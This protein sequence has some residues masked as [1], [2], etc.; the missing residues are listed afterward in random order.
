MTSTLKFATWNILFKTRGIESS[1]AKVSFLK[2]LDW[3]V[4]ALQEVTE[5]QWADFREMELGQ[6][7]FHAFDFLPSQGRSSMAHGATL[8]A[9]NGF[10]LDDCVLFDGLPK[11]ERGVGAVISSNALRLNVASWH[12]PNASGD[13]VKTKMR[14]YQSF[15]DWL[16]AKSGPT[17][18]GFDS[19]HWE[20]SCDLERPIVPDSD[21]PF[22]LENQTFS[23]SPPHNMNDAYVEHLKQNPEEYEEIVARHPEGPLETTYMRREKGMNIPERMD[24]IF[25]SKDIKTITVNHLY[26]EAVS[27]GSDHALVISD[28]SLPVMPGQ[29]KELQGNEL[30]TVFDDER[31]SDTDLH[32]K[33]LSNPEA[34]KKISKLAVENA[35]KRG[36]SQ[37]DAEKLYGLDEVDETR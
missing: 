28:L 23:R 9:R 7:Y 12:A 2:S 33:I 35:I 36:V 15:T 5:R 21:D 27:A 13:G 19:N 14:G 34:D 16:N 32:E 30:F 3:D 31:I 26:A 29:N 1:A 10:V 24:Y 20:R 6:S 22:L 8:I 11:P 4:L 18:T 37:K 25:V 17:I